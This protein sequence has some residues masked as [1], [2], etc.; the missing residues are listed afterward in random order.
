MT[1]RIDCQ[2][3][4]DAATVNVTVTGSVGGTVSL[5]AQPVDLLGTGEDSWPLVC[6]RTGD[7]LSVVS[8]AAV[9]GN[10]SFW[11][12]A[13]NAGVMSA[14]V[15][16]SCTGS[17]AIAT[18]C[19]RSVVA[20]L[21]AL[22]LPEIGTG[23][24]ERVHPSLSN[25]SVPA[26]ILS[27]NGYAEAEKMVLNNRDDIIYPIVLAIVHHHKFDDNDAL[28]LVELWRQAISDAFRHQRLPGVD[29]S[30]QVQVEPLIIAKPLEQAE[31]EGYQHWVCG[32]VLRCYCRQ[33]RG[34]NVN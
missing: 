33:K 25:L 34:L 27:P 32:M 28:P 3:N 16:S 18:R 6:T 21:K 5:Y 10:C 1:L 12:Y 19:R 22:N 20:V 4:R 15:L 30:I 29:E 17:L 2:D 7:G 14:P 9:I 13:V 11:M 26:I 24:Y 23:I 8:V 31:M